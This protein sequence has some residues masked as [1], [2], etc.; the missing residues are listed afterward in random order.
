MSKLTP[1]FEELS[2]Q[3]CSY[4]YGSKRSRVG[5]ARVEETFTSEEDSESSKQE[6]LS[7]EGSQ[8]SPSKDMSQQP[9]QDVS[10]EDTQEEIKEVKEHNY[11]TE[12]RVRGKFI[13]DQDNSDPKET[14]LT[15][16]FIEKLKTNEF[17]KKD[18]F[19]LL[20]Y[21]KNIDSIERM[22]SKKMHLPATERPYCESLHKYLSLRCEKAIECLERV[23]KYYK[24]QKLIFNQ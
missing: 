19:R 21:Q 15:K 16:K 13:T 6:D 14:S 12:K 4:M 10:Q 18:K 24:R 3:D 22:L 11:V 1:V 2:N 20:S 7:E 5:Q 23:R 17:A 9:S 8:E